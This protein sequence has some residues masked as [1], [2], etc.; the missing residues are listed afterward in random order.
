M[1]RRTRRRRRGSRRRERERGDERERE[2]EGEKENRRSAS[3]SDGRLFYPTSSTL[4]MMFEFSSM[5]G[6]KFGFSHSQ[7]AQQVRVCSGLKCK[8]TSEFWLW[9][10]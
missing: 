9:F 1:G 5:V 10:S 7:L 8:K 2:T 6:I 4:L 3:L